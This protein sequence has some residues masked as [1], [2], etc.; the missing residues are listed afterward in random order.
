MAGAC[1]SP[2]D[3]TRAAAAPSTE[4]HP[5]LILSSVALTS[6]VMVVFIVKPADP[7]VLERLLREYRTRLAAGVDHPASRE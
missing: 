5:L 7:F 3:Y 1:E 6:A 4:G 2:P